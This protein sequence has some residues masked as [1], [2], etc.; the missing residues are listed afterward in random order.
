VPLVRYWLSV[1]KVPYNVLFPCILFFC[2]IGTYSVNNNVDDIFITAGF[3]LIGY[4]MMRLELDAAPLMLGF[5]LG[6]MLEENFRR[7]LLLSRGSFTTFFTRPISGSLMAL[8]GAF[9]LW[10]VVTFVLQ[11][12]GRKALQAQAAGA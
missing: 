4:L 11:A 12:R 3:G 9:I 1:F 7:A 2:C 10:Q 6:P 8:I 5:I